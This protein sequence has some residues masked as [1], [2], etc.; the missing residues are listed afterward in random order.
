MHTR[1]PERWKHDHVFGQDRRTFGER[2]TWLVIAL[3]GTA[4]VVEIIAGV[5]FGSMALLADGRTARL[6]VWDTA[7]QECFR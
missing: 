3:T 4:M 6:A 1:N 7:G 5:V 2:R